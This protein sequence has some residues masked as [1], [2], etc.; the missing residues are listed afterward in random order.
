M[1]KGENVSY[2]FGLTLLGLGSKQMEQEQPI[3]LS[4]VI[5]SLFNFSPEAMDDISWQG[6]RD[7]FMWQR[8][9]SCKHKC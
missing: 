5:S 2:N 4:K 8:L 7:L 6:E 1:G 3:W 9:D